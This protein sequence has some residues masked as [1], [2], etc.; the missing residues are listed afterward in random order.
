MLT[1]ALAK[2]TG[3][4]P[5]VVGKL[6]RAALRSIVEHLGVP[7]SDL[8]VIGD[9]LA[10]DIALGRLAGIGRSSSGAA[11]AAGRHRAVPERRRPDAVVDSVADLLDR[12]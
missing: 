1:A 10:L 12:L 6:S 3:R 4:R 2:V 8:A 9:D 11:S 7:S 5:I